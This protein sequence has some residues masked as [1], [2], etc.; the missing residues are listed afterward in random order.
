MHQRLEDGHRP[1]HVADLSARPREQQVRRGVQ[2]GITG[3]ADELRQEPLGPAQLAAFEADQRVEQQVQP[4]PPCG[5]RRARHGGPEAVELRIT[6]IVQ[7]EAGRQRDVAQHARVARGQGLLP[8]AQQQAALAQG[9][10]EVG[11]RLH[12]SVR[13]AH[14][15]Q[16]V[17]SQ[18]GEGHRGLADGVRLPELPT[19]GGRGGEQDP[20]LDLRPQV[21]G[22]VGLLHGVP[23]RAEGRFR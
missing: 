23:Q 14:E 20:G 12:Q 10:A 2:Q 11:G 5:A 16:R 9:R 21:V 6:E 17:A 7:D 13:G 3:S 18:L 4:A 22:A 1:V 19:S 15:Q 8:R